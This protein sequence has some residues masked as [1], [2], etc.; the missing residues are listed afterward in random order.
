ME[1]YNN[2][3]KLISMLRIALEQKVNTYNHKEYLKS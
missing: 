2:N 1:V 3:K